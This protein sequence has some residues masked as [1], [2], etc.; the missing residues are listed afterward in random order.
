MGRQ[1]ISLSNGVLIIVVKF[2]SLQIRNAE[3]RCG[4]IR[5]CG[6]LGSA[7]AGCWPDSAFLSA[8]WGILCLGRHSILAY[9]ERRNRFQEARIE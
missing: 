7:R 8:Y 9:N 2:S 1:L 6:N 5:R 4:W 3:R